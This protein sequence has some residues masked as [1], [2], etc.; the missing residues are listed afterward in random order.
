MP[1]FS[2]EAMLEIKELGINIFVINTYKYDLQC[3]ERKESQLNI[4]TLQVKVVA[5]LAALFY[6]QIV[7][8]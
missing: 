2:E 8:L 1:V 5:V 4:K 7:N 6:I 3:L